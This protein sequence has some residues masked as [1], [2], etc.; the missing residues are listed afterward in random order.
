[1]PS[2][3]ASFGA[4]CGSPA[5]SLAS[6]AAPII[7]TTAQVAIAN[8]PTPF[9][10]LA[11]GWSN[12]AAGPTPLPISLAGIGMPGCFLL[13]S[14]EVLGLTAPATGAGTAAYDWPLPN[15]GSLIGLHVYLQGWALAP[16]ENA[17]ELIVSNGLEW[18]IGNF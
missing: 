5:L 10:F 13:Q 9:A 15:L 1:M 3:T 14:A 2:A 17:A 12:T 16:G 8:T 4:G 11:V 6:S 7:G 18:V